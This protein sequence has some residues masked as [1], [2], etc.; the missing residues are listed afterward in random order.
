MS[1]EVGRYVVV[2]QS[3][4]DHA[5]ATGADTVPVLAYS[6]PTVGPSQP[7]PADYIGDLGEFIRAL[8][9]DPS[10]Q[11]ALDAVAVRES[12]DERWDEAPYRHA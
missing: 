8:T 7:N 1:E 10:E 4:I 6:E 11:A 3:D 2:R 9:D 12:E 5:R